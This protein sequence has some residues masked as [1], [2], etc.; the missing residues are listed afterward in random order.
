MAH[1]VRTALYDAAL[2]VMFTIQPERIHDIICGGL[3]VL[4]LVTPLN[5]V[6]EKSPSPVRWALPQA[7]TRM[8]PL[9]MRG[10]PLASATR[11]SVPSRL[12]RNR[13]TPLPGCFA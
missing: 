11:S 5:R 4:Q 12:R 1:P 9:P 6:L 2:K 10:R 8:Q 3:G 13:A 7:L